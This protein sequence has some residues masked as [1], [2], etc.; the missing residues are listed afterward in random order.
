[1]YPNDY[2]PSGVPGNGKR[3][4]TSR[5]SGVGRT[6]ARHDGSSANDGRQAWNYPP[7]GQNPQPSSMQGQRRYD[8]PRGVPQPSGYPVQ[9]YGQ[10]QW[11]QPVPQSWQSMPRQPRNA[12]VPQAAQWTQPQA[13]YDSTP[14]Q[15]S[16]DNGG[17]PPP[18]W[19]PPAPIKPPPRFPGRTILLVLVILVVL[20][21]AGVGGYYALQRHQTEQFVE[22]YNGLFCQGVYVD[23]IHLGGMTQQQGID[24]VTAQAQ[25]RSN[26]WQVRLMYQGNLVA[27]INA[28]QL[29]MRTDVVDTLR[30]AWNQGHTGDIYQR[31]AAMETLAQQPYEVY[32]AMPSGDTAVIDNILEEIRSNVYRPAQDAAIAEF[33]PNWT[34]PFTFRDE[35]V[36]RSLDTEPI[37]TQLYQMLSTLTSGDIEIT[38]TLTQPNVLVSQLRDQVALIST[39]ATPISSKSTE[40]RNNNIRRSFQSINGYVLKPGANFSFNGVVGQRTQKNG[41]FKAIEYAYGQEV[42]GVGGGVCQASTTLY[43]AAV[44]AGLE[45]VKREPHSD[46][47]SYAEYGKDATV[48]WEGNRKIDMV[49]RNN[50]DA[51]IYMVAGVVPDPSNHKRLVAKVSFYGQSLGD[52][53]Y[54]LETKTTE[55]LPI[56]DE[57]KYIKDKKQEYVTYKDQ[58]KQTSKG[59][60]GYVVD[61]YRLKFVNGH[62]VERTFLYTDRYEAKPKVI[63]V[64]TLDR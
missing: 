41:F 38:P 61:S 63:Y 62:E 7:P 37:K 12:P 13:R 54:S 40:N 34:Y 22:A 57:P 15:G 17:Y 24:T 59:K 52:V 25:Q 31:R 56:P 42:E 46:A 32:T 6:N 49:F 30:E 21:A 29:G 8:A 19:Q 60:E 26:A 5:T 64:G 20:A 33:N 16:Y 47:V 14:P 44:L 35:V 23:G 50:T 51:P 45:I 10:P 53:T 28:G 27:E 43:Q 11:E 18:A 55:V 36:G 9:P 48:Y 39:A 2:M 58:E 1:M 3:R 4:S